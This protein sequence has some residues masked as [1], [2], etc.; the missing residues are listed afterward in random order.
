MNNGTGLQTPRSTSL[1]SAEWTSHGSNTATNHGAAR[2]LQLTN[3]QPYILN[4]PQQF[5]TPDLQTRTTVQ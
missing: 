4:K 5:N 3:Q 2:S 1:Q